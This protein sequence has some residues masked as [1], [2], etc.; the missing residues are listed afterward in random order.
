MMIIQLLLALKINETLSSYYQIWNRSSDS[1]VE[2]KNPI[3]E[4]LNKSK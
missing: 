3:I 2:N 4:T 1:N